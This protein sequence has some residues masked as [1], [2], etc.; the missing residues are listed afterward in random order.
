MTLRERNSTIK[1]MLIPQTKT[2]CVQ[3]K[4]KNTIVDEKMINW[5]SI[6]WII[7]K[8]TKYFK[9]FNF[10]YTKATRN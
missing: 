10:Y 5:Y 4:N 3:I 6:N 2:S 7:E 9:I 1:F 8:E